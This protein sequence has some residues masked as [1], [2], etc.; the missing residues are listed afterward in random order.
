MT[1]IRHQQNENSHVVGYIGLSYDYETSIL[2]GQEKTAKQ[3]P[4]ARYQMGHQISRS[5]MR[6][7]THNLGMP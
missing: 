2:E 3:P 5:G 6:V 7:Y 4:E 1:V